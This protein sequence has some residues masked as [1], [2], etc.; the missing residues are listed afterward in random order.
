MF[1]TGARDQVPSPSSTRRWEGTEWGDGGGGDDGGDSDDDGGVCVLGWGRLDA[2][3][4]AT[5]G[6]YL[7]FS[8]LKVW[9]WG[10]GAGRE[11]TGAGSYPSP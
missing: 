7:Y 6:V 5:P 1:R 3:A 9:E 2:P 10:G 8:G 4:L 11:R